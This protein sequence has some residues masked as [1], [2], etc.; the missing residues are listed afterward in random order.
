MRKILVCLFVVFGCGESALGPNDED[1]DVEDVQDV[2][3]EDSVETDEAE[4]EVDIGLDLDLDIVADVE[5]DPEVD[6]GHDVEVEAEEPSCGPIPVTACSW[7]TDMEAEVPAAAGFWAA[8]ER[9]DRGPTCDGGDW[10]AELPGAHE[11][12]GLFTMPFVLMPLSS[13]S[14]PNVW[15]VSFWVRFDE[16]GPRQLAALTDVPAGAMMSW[17]DDGTYLPTGRWT[18]VEIQV[19]CTTRTHYEW[20]VLVDGT[21]A[22]GVTWPHPVDAPCEDSHRLTFGVHGPAGRLDN[23]CF[24]ARGDILLNE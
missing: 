5:V 15:W 3:A 4:L 14:P 2:A 8:V 21:P 11:G 22:S 19:Y 20:V 18:N 9:V 23:I 16:D 6:I 13:I 1:A 17:Q 24:I 7:F 10:A 12:G